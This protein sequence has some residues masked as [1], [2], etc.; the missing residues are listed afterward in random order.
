MK[1]L[2]S[3]LLS[4]SPLARDIGLLV[5]RVSGLFMAV[6][7]GWGKIPPSERFISGVASMGF[8]APELFAWAAGLT[9][10]VGGLLIALGLM[11]RPASFF[12][13]NT[14]LV[15]AFIRHANDGF[16]KQELALMYALVC[17]ALIGAGAGRLSLD[18][19]LRKCLVQDPSD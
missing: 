19:L 9:E 6:A 14:M 8:P 11:T 16:G 1:K 7:H 18:E 5:L 13:L 10:L 15:A 17:V 2:W 4:D 12:L 3:T